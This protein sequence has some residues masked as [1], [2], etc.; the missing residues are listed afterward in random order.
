MPSN[1][2]R[3][4][5][6]QRVTGDNVSSMSQEL[7]ARRPRNEYLARLVVAIER[8][9]DALGGYIDTLLEGCKSP[10][11]LMKSPSHC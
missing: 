2:S 6:L 9:S 4:A 10:H 11:K 8:L 3:A 7:E 5:S 1:V